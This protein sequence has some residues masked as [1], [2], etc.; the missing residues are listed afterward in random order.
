MLQTQSE[1]CLT[2]EKVILSDPSSASN[3]PSNLSTSHPPRKGCGCT[4]SGPSSRISPSSQMFVAVTAEIA[5]Y[6]AF[7]HAG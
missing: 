5:S 1:G 6:L 7:L 4:S 2:C 3:S